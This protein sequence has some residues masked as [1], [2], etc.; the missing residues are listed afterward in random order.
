MLAELIDRDETNTE[1]IQSMT[2]QLKLLDLLIIYCKLLKL[3]SGGGEE[4]V[5]GLAAQELAS[6][7]KVIFQMIYRLVQNNKVCSQV[8]IENHSIFN[9]LLMSHPESIGLII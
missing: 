7:L 4:G 3:K 9:E 2:K 1:M 6:T 8:I 5:F